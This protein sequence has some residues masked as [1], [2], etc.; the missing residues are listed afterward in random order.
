[1]LRLITRFGITS[2]IRLPGCR[3]ITGRIERVTTCTA[4]TV[5]WSRADSYAP[6]TTRSTA[7]VAFGRLSKQLRQE[8]LSSTTYTPEEKGRLL[9]SHFGTPNRSPSCRASINRSRAL[10]CD[11]T[12]HLAS[13]TRDPTVPSVW[14]KLHHSRIN[15]CKALSCTI[16]LEDEYFRVNQ[17]CP[18][19]SD[20]GQC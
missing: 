10:G 3:S 11:D 2:I 16:Q 6:Y 1:M 5:C 9:R 18:L 4:V 20:T 17:C 14:D 15:P 19:L 12:E 13:F 8:A 7:I